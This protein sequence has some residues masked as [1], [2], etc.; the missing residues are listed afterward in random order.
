MK[1]PTRV[2]KERFIIEAAEEIFSTVGFK[3]ARM[4]DV[5]TQAKITKVTLYS[6]FQSK[7]NLY[8]AVT[9][10]G[11]NALAESYITCA[12]TYAGLSG[13]EVSI[14]LME[15]FINFCEK[16]YLY[17]EA[18]LDYFSLVRSTNFIKDET[19]LTDALKE[20]SYFAKV[21]EL[22]NLPYKIVAK[23][24][25]RGIDDGSINPTVDPMFQ[26]I[27]SWT[28]IVGYVKVLAASGN[29]EAPLFGISL[30]ELKHYILEL[31]RNILKNPSK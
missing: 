25:Q 21:Q 1:E 27:Q 8:M 5:A 19:K 17:S 12:K 7:E 16:N 2:K 18:L 15:D 11:L 3:N 4:E 14:N 31:K 23:E 30:K 22:Q 24:I 29:A 26:T 13:L 10:R 9:Y 20:S 6:Y 28:M